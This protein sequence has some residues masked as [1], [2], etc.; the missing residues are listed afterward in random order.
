MTRSS[1]PAMAT[2]PHCRFAHLL[3]DWH[4]KKGLRRKCRVCFLHAWSSYV[5]AFQKFKSAISGRGL[6]PDL[7]RSAA[8]LTQPGKSPDFWSLPGLVK[9]LAMDLFSLHKQ[10]HKRHGHIAARAFLC[11]SIGQFLQT[12]GISRFLSLSSQCH[13]DD[14]A[15][16]WIIHYF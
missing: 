5:S 1:T 16:E 2:Q 7:A 14:C 8:P 4:K 13:F 11:S 3:R 6:S 15:E 10:F 12:V 9:K